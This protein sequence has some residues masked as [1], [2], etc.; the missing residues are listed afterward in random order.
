MIKVLIFVF[1][2]VFS[3][4]AQN[5]VSVLEFDDDKILEGYNLF[6]PNKQSTVY[7]N[8][9][10]GEIVN[11]WDNGLSVRLGADLYLLENGD[12]LKAV[13]N[14]DIVG[15]PTIGAGGAGGIIEIVNWENQLQWRYIIQDSL[16]RQHHDIHMMPNGHILAIV[17][18][19]HFFTDIVA[20][21]FDT[22]SHVQQEL[23]AD[24]VV[25]IDPTTDEIVWQWN[26]WD[27]MVQDYDVT[28]SNFGNV[29][30]HQELCDINYQRFTF[31]RSDWMHTNA[32]DYNPELDQIILSVRNFQEIWIIDHSTTTAEAATHVG[33]Y[34]GKGGDILYRWG[35]PES[36]QNGTTDDRGTVLSA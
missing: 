22:V 7:L 19:R 14:V 34:S 18:D 32:I 23:W 9:N 8:N 33:G 16:Q 6:M 4:K 30:E 20:M 27:H 10:C 36:Y 28:K 12:L 2:L 25:E 3:L 13:T 11:K 21:G 31:N 17:W 5:T 24:K 1:F 26:A 15:G 35:N 29:S